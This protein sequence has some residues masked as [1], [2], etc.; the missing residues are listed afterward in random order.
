MYEMGAFKYGKYD[1]M[2]DM[3]IRREDMRAPNEPYDIIGN[4]FYHFT[5]LL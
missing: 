5:I 2:H 1:I 4:S 3:W